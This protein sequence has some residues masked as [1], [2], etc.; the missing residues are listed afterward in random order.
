M[1]APDISPDE[2]FASLGN[3]T[4]IAIIRV[5]G[6][7]GGESLSFSELR[8]RVGTRDSG[9]FNYHLRRLVDQFVRRTDDGKYELSYAGARVVGAIYSGEFTRRGSEGTIPLESDCIGCGTQLEATYEGE[10]VQI[11]C[12]GCDEIETGF[13]FPP[14]GIE[15]RTPAELTH[16][17]D[18]W[19]T[20]VFTLVGDC[21]CYNCAGNMTASITAE[22]EYL[23]E[24][25]P[26]CLEFSCDRCADI[27]TVSVSSY[28]FFHPDVIGFY[29]DHGVD[30]HAIEI[31]NARSFV[32]PAITV[33]AES[34]WRIESTFE[35]DESAFTIVLDE[36]LATA[37]KP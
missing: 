8:D 27:T 21:L 1:T 34:P 24:D 19:L 23:H 4:R 30:L 20:S 17:F 10:V 11:R 9:Q 28:L 36:D 31:W 2:A 16:V 37:V 35:L 29:A 12:P 18:R 7:A 33:A 3:E 6:E 14:G 13:G 26:V 25:D 22:S 32:D 5:L 15:D